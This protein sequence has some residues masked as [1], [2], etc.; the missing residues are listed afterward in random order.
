VLGLDGMDGIDGVNGMDAGV[1]QSG[2]VWVFLGRE[3]R[4]AGKQARAG[5][6]ASS[7]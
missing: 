6:H 1:L 4:Q 2:R 5:K 7:I 3:S